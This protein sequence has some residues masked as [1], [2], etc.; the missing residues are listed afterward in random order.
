MPEEKDRELRLDLIELRNAVR[1]LTRAVDQLKGR[2][3]GADL[4]GMPPCREGCDM[5]AC[6]EGCDMPACRSEGCDM[7]ACRSCC[8]A[9]RSCCGAC[10]A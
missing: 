3:Q 4:R 8:R 10:A 9:C 5:P 7:P 6:R 1:Q 2:L